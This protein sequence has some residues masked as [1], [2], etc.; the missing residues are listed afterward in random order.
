MVFKWISPYIS[1]KYWLDLLLAHQV[2]PICAGFAH[3]SEQQGTHREWDCSNSAQG[4][5]AR[6]V[7]LCY[8]AQA[9]PDS[10][11]Q[12]YSERYFTLSLIGFRTF[13]QG[14]RVKFVII[15]SQH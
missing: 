7:H 8:S 15:V 1:Q 11:T 13:V 12:L 10:H 4:A 2:S 9:A 5:Y 14:S 3:N 6:F